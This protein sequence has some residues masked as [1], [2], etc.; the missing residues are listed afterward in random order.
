MKSIYQGKIYVQFSKLFLKCNKNA[1]LSREITQH[2]MKS[3]FYLEKGP[4]YYFMFSSCPYFLDETLDK[5]YCN[6]LKS[7]KSTNRKKDITLL[8]FVTFS[9]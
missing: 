9:L 2:K 7:Y 4:I 8:H 1:V 6:Q 5:V 3:L